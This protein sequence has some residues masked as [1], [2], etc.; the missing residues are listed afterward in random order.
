MSSER[1]LESLSPILE[2]EN[3]DLEYKLGLSLI[4]T[5]KLGGYGLNRFIRP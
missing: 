1:K 5:T 3:E 2:L 4:I